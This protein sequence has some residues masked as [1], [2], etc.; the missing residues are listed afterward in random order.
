MNC[1][2][3]GGVD[4]LVTWMFAVNPP[5]SLTP[6]QPAPTDGSEVKM[7]VIGMKSQQLLGTNTS[8]GLL[9]LTDDANWVCDVILYEAQETEEEPATD[10]S[11]TP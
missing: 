3:S 4:M 10:P 6:I 1:C 5:S 2:M 7:P 8:G 9:L 11:Q